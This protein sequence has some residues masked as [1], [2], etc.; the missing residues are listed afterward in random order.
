[1]S[2]DSDE[3][4]IASDK[5]VVA[6]EVMAS[7]IRIL[8]L[9]DLDDHEIADLFEVEAGEGTASHHSPPADFDDH[10]DVTDAR[11]WKLHTLAENE[12]FSKELDRF[13]KRV[14]A[15]RTDQ[16][17]GPADVRK[18]AD[19]CLSAIPAFAG[20]QRWYREQCAQ[21]GWEFALCRDEWLASASD[22]MLDHEHKVVFFDQSPIALEL[23][24]LARLIHEWL[25]NGLADVA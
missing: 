19:L 10:D 14:S 18:L 25:F 13:A 4:P 5:F 11:P 3:L 15:L 23:H 7:A 22:E 9:L 16:E 21:H 17:P 1:M 2:D 24:T 8:S 12:G 20:A 6:S